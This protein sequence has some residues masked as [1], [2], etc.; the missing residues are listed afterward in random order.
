[1]NSLMFIKQSVECKTSSRSK[2]SWLKEITEQHAELESPASFWYW[3]ALA[4]VSAVLK[5]SVYLDKFLYKLYPNI[6]V[7]LHAESGI[8]KGPPISMAKQLVREVNNTRIFSGRA[9]I[10]GI[11]KKLGESETKPG[12]V[13]LKKSVG[14]ICSSE[15]TSSI[16]EDKVATKILTDLYDRQ[17]NEGDWGSLLKMEE[18]TLRDPTVAM[19]TASNEAMSDD[20]FTQSAIT[21]GY[22][23]R[24]F[25]IYENKRHTIN[26][27]MY[28]LKTTIDYK[29]SATYLKELAKLTG[30]FAMDDEARAYFDN[31]YRKFRDLTDSSQIRDPTGTLNRFDDS[32]LKVAMLVALGHAPELHIKIEH[33]KEAIEHCEKLVGNVRK[34]TFGTGSKNIWAPLKAMI[35]RELVTRPQ[36]LITWPQLNEKYW[37]HANKTEMREIMESFNESGAVRPIMIGSIMAYEMTPDQVMKY[38]RFFAGKEE[39]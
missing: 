2:M 5:D 31:W 19:L 1:M 11:L 38:E 22:F 32:V 29:K 9:S 18:F 8:K 10:Q 16:V 23:A 28:E 3:S 7:M 39:K 36:H 17:Y 33:I 24:T 30:Q 34:T 26:S 27:L 37:M 20:F 4:A 15:L 25:I 14:F 6:Y 12:G 35:L 13:I 21:G